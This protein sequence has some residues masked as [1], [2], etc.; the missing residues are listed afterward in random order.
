MLFLATA[1]FFVPHYEMTVPGDVGGPVVDSAQNFYFTSADSK[2]SSQTLNRLDPDGK[3][4]YRVIP[5]PAGSVAKSIRPFV[6]DAAGNVYAVTITATPGSNSSTCQ[7]TKIDPAGNLV[8]T[9]QVPV[10]VCYPASTGQESIAVGADGSVFLA[11]SEFAAIP[12]NG[13]VFPTSSGA[14]VASSAAAMGQLNAYVIKVNPQGS[15]IVYSTWLAPAPAAPLKYNPSTKEWAL[16]VDSQGN[17]YVAGST[18]DPGFPTTTGAFMTDCNC[19]EAKPGIFL[20]KLSPDGSRATY[21][22]FISPQ[23][24]AA[25]SALD[26]NPLPPMISVSLNSTMQATV[27]Q[28]Q[29]NYLPGPFASDA[30]LAIMMTTITPSG[31]AIVNGSTVSFRARGNIEATPDGQGNLLVTGNYA[32]ANMAVSPGAFT[33]G[34]AFAAV[35]RISDGTALYATRL[36]GGSAA[37]I[38]SDGAGGFVLTGALLGFNPRQSTQVTRMVPGNA[39]PPMVLGVSNAGGARVSPGL[40][41]GEIVIIWGTG[42]GPD[43]GVAGQFDATGN[44]PR[45]LGGTAV[46]VNGVAVPLLYAGGQQV[47]AIVPF[48][49][50]GG[51]SAQLRVVVNGAE[52]VATLPQHDADPEMFRSYDDGAI[53]YLHA[54]AVNQDGT[55]NTSKNPAKLGTTVGI[56]VSGAGMLTPTPQDG[57]PGLSGEQLAEGVTAIARYL[58]PDGSCCQHLA[59]TRPSAGSA[60][61]LPAGVV[62]VDI[63]LPATLPTAQHELGITLSFDAVAAYSTDGAVWITP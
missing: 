35:V 60:P 22:T 57:H 40:A 26:T 8:Y 18:N 36:P 48:S 58:A 3:T 63:Q 31:N 47:N 29:R 15:D 14:Y 30:P 24:F 61:G 32:A 37:A 11:G 19:V 53:P 17:A 27:M 23:P 10:A 56:F 6:P 1:L 54:F 20:V 59:M 45:Q 44:L 42:L 38:V 33:N 13:E 49:I 28:V 39:G 55:L 34:A 7:L 5:A 2:M 16:A 50:H 62:R 12:S 43:S 21:S 25:F 4:V 51:T 41:P 52:A 46:M 9:F